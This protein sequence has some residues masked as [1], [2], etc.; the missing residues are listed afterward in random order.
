MTGPTLGIS[1]MTK[2]R[3]DEK[4]SP[5]QVLTLRHGY[6]ACVSYVDAQVGKVLA[7]LEQL[8]LDENT[9]VVLWGDHGYALGEQA[10]WCKGTNF[11]L[12]TRVPLIMRVP[13]VTTSGTV[14]EAM[15]EYVDIYPTLS[16]LAGLRVPDEL[17]G[18]SLVPVLRDP[19]LPGR[20]AVLSQFARPFSRSVPEVMGYSIRTQTYRY[21]RWLEWTDKKVLAEEL[22]DYTCPENVDQLGSYQVEKE[23]LVQDPAYARIRGRLRLDM[24]EA[25]RKRGSLT[26]STLS[27]EKPKKKA[28]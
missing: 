15:I 11:E 5:Q 12:D 13:G 23:N 25:L 19:C 21:T 27:T 14:T 20:Q 8:G 28:R 4:V 3:A 2:G 16:E 9:I 1:S 7:A 26:A 22:Y 18:L 17:D 10:R 6:Y 24:D